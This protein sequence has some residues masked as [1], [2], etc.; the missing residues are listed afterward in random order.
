M[1]GSPRLK[2]VLEDR[3]IA[4]VI[5]LVAV[6]AIYAQSLGYE[7]V[8]DDHS[9]IIKNRLIQTPANIPSMFFLED[10]L[11]AS[12]TGYYRPLIPVIDTFA[13]MALGADPVWFHLLSILYHMVTVVL[14]YFLSLRLTGS[15]A[16]ALLAAALF[17]LH[18]VNTE[19]VAFVSAKNNMICSIFILGSV[20]CF[21][22]HR[23]KKA[24]GGWYALAASTGLL[25]L[26]ILSKEFAIMVPF[27]LMAY[28]RLSGRLRSRRDLAAYIP[29]VVVLVVYLGMRAFVLRGS[30]GAGFSPETFHIRMASM[31]DVLLAYIR[32]TLVPVGQ[33]ALYTFELVPGPLTVVSG[34]ILAALIWASFSP[35][36][37]GLAGVPAAWF[38]LFLMPVMNIIPV[39][40]SPMAE[41]YMYIPLIG[42]VLFAGALYSRFEAS[43]WSTPA[44]LFV[45]ACF[46]ILTFMRIPVWKNDEVLYTH[47]TETEGMSW[48]G[49]YHLGVTK[50]KQG[51]YEEAQR[52]WD[53][54][55]KFIPEMQDKRKKLGLMYER[56]GQYMKA[57]IEFRKVLSARELPDDYFNLANVLVRQGKAGGAEKAYLRAIELDPSGVGPYTALS[58]LYEKSG[59]KDKALGVLRQ[60]MENAPG[61]S[62]P[63]NRA[64]VILSDMGMYAEAVG[65]FRKA[66]EIDPS[67]TECR[68]NLTQVEKLLYG[69]K[70]KR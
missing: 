13:Y 63:Y 60:A 25:F 35:R 66:L 39:S 22:R 16:G 28:E 17:G 23:D 9:A 43:K 2:H 37:R 19:S 32:L 49:W 21:L 53:I 12:S 38:L 45:L 14:V 26:G 65:Y 3:R 20:L 24:Q 54:S 44:A 52:L 50:Y 8:Y 70:R 56:Q 46:A 4:L 47:M 42:A 64:G 34:I 7:F 29:L 6:F 69:G 30:E 51:D 57:E 67:C 11:M 59:R 36:W 5:L 41:R 48:K 55:E 1:S 18:P 61:E 33:R 62:G 40:G 58:G 15:G 31:L 27:A 68:Y 10:K